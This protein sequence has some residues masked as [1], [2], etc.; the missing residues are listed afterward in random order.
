MKNRFNMGEFKK[1]EKE[2][3]EQKFSGLFFENF[4]GFC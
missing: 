1:I 3:T 2:V 4:R